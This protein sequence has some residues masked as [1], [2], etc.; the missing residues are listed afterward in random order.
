MVQICEA[1]LAHGV[2]PRENCPD[3]HDVF[4]CQ[5]CRVVFQRNDYEK[6]LTTNFHKQKVLQ[7]QRREAGLSL[8]VACT[9]CSVDISGAPQYQ[10]HAQG[11]RHKKKMAEQGLDVDPGPE[12][13]DVPSNCTRCDTCSS[14]VLTRDFEK[15]INGRRHSKAVEFNRLRGA[16]DESEKDKNGVDVSPDTIDF[17]LVAES[18]NRNATWSQTVT[19][20]NSNVTA[21]NVVEARLF[22]RLTTQMVS[23]G[24]SITQTTLPKRI[25]A[26]QEITLTVVFR[27]DGNNGRYED[28]LELVFNDPSLNKRFGITRTLLGIM[29]VKQDY[30]L[31]KA[32]RPYVRP[33][34]TTQLQEPIMGVVPGVAPPSIAEFKWKVKLLPYTAPPSLVEI[35]A[36]SESKDLRPSQIAARIREAFIPSGLTPA[37]Y[38]RNFTTLLWIEEDRARRDLTQYDMDEAE[39]EPSGRGLY[40]LEVAGLAEKRPSLIVTDRIFVKNYGSPVNRWFEGYVHVVQMDA[41]LLRFAASFNSYRGQRYHVRFDLNRLVYRR[42][43][44]GLNTAFTETR[45][46]FPDANDIAHL[47]PPTPAMTQSLSLTDRKIEDNPPQLE[48]IAAIVNRPAGSVPFVVFGPPGTGKT[49]TIVE[50]IRQLVQ[51]KP[52]TRILACAPSNSAADLI[53]ERLAGLG[54][55]QVF[56]LNAYS[57]GTENVP[58]D[59]IDLSRTQKEGTET[60]FMVPT[61]EDLKKYRVVVS[62]CLS[63]SLPYGIGIPRGH[64]S[65]IFIDEAGQATEP[66]VMISVKTMAD[67]TT[68]VILSGDSK[69]LGPI[70]RSPVCRELGFTKSYLDRLMENPIYD[71]VTGSGITI[72]KLVK[73]WRSHTSILHFPNKEFYGGDLVACGDPLVTGSMTR[74]DGLVKKNFPIIFHGVQ[75]KDMREA[76]S[77]SY[78]NIEEASQVNKY[79]KSLMEDRKLRLKPEYIGVISPYHAQVQKIRK[80]VKIKEIKVGSVE[81]YQGQEKR[82][83]II[84][85]VRSSVEHVQFDLRHTLGFVANARRFNVA[86][87]RAQALLIVIGDPTV[88]SLDP[89][90]REFMNYVHTNGGWTGKRIDWDPLEE[91]D[92][93]RRYDAD[94]RDRA[95][96]DLDELVARTKEE[97]LRQAED[98]GGHEAETLEANVEQPW[99]EDE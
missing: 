51:T 67:P 48:A 45:V 81:E 33:K 1:I 98:L 9:V 23:S 57:R 97:I 60:R 25:K 99:R 18:S 68:N 44:Q 61:A 50:A 72:T 64:F 89:L 79:I 2:C 47:P 71:E 56:R 30:E 19:V 93:N 92:R 38:A 70:V 90:W 95:V 24:F 12:E 26:N 80:L 13:V 55:T 21:V 75:G 63:A 53:A 46:L 8:P 6:H 77:P 65:H 42:M 96:S 16:L 34:R 73:N 35:L 49:V 83:M 37:S 39:L 62:T 88:L 40:R 36:D 28:R 58:R 10:L 27:P 76:S 91:V 87:T 4:N 82:I 5:T 41:V 31:L 94:R 66:E 52:A 7:A 74:W 17:G 11:R 84:S 22:S 14:N 29:G 85:T 43:H 86:V 59:V 54:K 32:S 20:H 15:H 3:S 69:Q 78:F